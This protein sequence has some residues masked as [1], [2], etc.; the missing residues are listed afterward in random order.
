M[1]KS[2]FVLGEADTVLGFSLIGIDGLATD[3]PDMATRKLD[4]LRRDEDVGLILVTSGLAGR[5]R[6]ALEHILAATA[7]PLVFEI[8]DRSHA[9]ERPPLREQLRRA[10][11]VSV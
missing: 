4:E 3:D 10:L 8:P 11:G 5:M 9:I 7:L 2:V 1:D 6:P